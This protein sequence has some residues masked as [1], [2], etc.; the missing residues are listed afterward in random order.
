MGLPLASRASFPGLVRRIRVVG[1]SG[2]TRPNPD[3]S[4]L[5]GILGIKF[6]GNFRPPSGN[7]GDE[8]CSG[9]LPGWTMS[10][11]R[12]NWEMLG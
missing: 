12:L 2:K 8:R 1:N 4:G 6:G 11:G 10:F 5:G 3:K 9:H 7:L